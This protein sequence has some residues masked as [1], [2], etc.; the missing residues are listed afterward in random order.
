MS[1]LFISIYRYLNRRRVLLWGSLFLITTLLLFFAVRVR[2][3]EDP[4]RFFPDSEEGGRA[5]AL[6]SGISAKDRVVTL[7]ELNGEA[8]RVDTLSGDLLNGS[9]RLIEVANLFERELMKRAGESLIK[10]SRLTVD[11][12]ELDRSISY[13]YNNLPIFME[14]EDYARLDSAVTP[15][16]IE[17]MVKGALSLLLSPAGGAFAPYFSR[18]PLNIGTRFLSIYDSLRMGMRFRVVDDYIFSQDKSALLYII[19]PQSGSGESGRNRELASTLG[20][21]KV[22]FAKLA[23]DVKISSMGGPVVGV[24]NAATIKKDTFVT[25]TIA[26]FIIAALFAFTFRDIRSILPLLLPAAFGALFALAFMSIRD[27]VSAIAI[28]AGAAVMGIALSY[29]IHIVSHLRHVCSIEQLLKDL[30]YPLTVGSFTTIGAFAGLQFTQSS[31]LRDF[32]LFSALTLIGTTLF[33]LIYLPHMLKIREVHSVGRIILWLERFS[34]QEFE[35]RRWLIFAIVALFVAGV[36]MSPKVRFDSDM[37]KLSIEPEEHIYTS[38]R[39][40]SLFGGDESRVLLLS[41]GESFDMAARSYRVSDSLINSFINEGFVEK[42]ASLSALLPPLELQRERLQTWSEFW[43]GGKREEVAL[44]LK[45]SAEKYGLNSESFVGFYDI[46]T[47]DYQCSQIDEK[48]Y[49]HLPSAI[50]EWVEGDTSSVML[51][52]QL[53]IKEEMKERVYGELALYKEIVVVDRAHF[54]S[55]WADGIKSD[56]NLILLI[57]SLLVFVT[58]LISYGRVELAILAF[59]PMFV[60]WV[61]ILGL[62]ALFGIPFNIVNILLATF[63]FGIGDDFSIF[64]LDG[65]SSEYE[66]GAKTLSSHK[67]AIFFST[68]TVIIGMG[69]ML[70]AQ[71]PALQSV[72]L[73]SVLG[74]CAVWIVAY[75]IQP[76]LYR[77]LITTPA[78]RGQTPVTFSGVLLMLLTFSV[79]TFG[80][81]LLGV[82][83]V[84]LAFVPVKRSVKRLFFRKVLRAVVFIPVRLSPTVRIFREN[85][86]SEDFSK[87]SVIVVN[88]QSFIDILMMLSLYPKIV[89]MTNSWV[90]NS[91]F[92]GHIVRYAGFLYHNDG[93]DN[94]IEAIKERVAEGYS[95]LIFPEGTRSDD[96]T[97]HRFHKGAFKIAKELSLDIL[98]VV[99]Y[100]NGNLLSKRQPFYIK[101]GTIGYRVL[102][103]VTFAERGSLC[104]YR[105]LCK[106][107]NKSM[108]EEYS[109]LR[110]RYD[111]PENDF[112]YFATM[113]NFIFKGPVLEWYMRVKIKMERRYS[114]FH[115]LIPLNAR[116]TDLGCGYGP[117]CFML[118]LTSPGRVVTGIDYDRDK[119]EIAKSCYT[120]GISFTEGDI[121]MAPIPESDVFIVCDTLHYLLPDNQRAVL[122]RVVERTADGGFIIIRDGDSER[123]KK[124]RVTKLSEWFSINLLNFNKSV[125]SPCFMGKSEILSAAA[126]LGCSVEVRNNDSYTS[127]TIYILR[128][129][130][131]SLDEKI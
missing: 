23:P 59:L 49:R 50:Q 52:S 81:L 70:F 27:G 46:I 125:Q 38:G 126:E 61:I 47:R 56:F 51:V 92:F 127:N 2:L 86:F 68:L 65:L 75:T 91:P 57:S 95:V 121:N 77:F 60:S 24:Y 8:D 53:F 10:S 55:L 128:P 119:I 45:E 34:S 66:R 3:I 117:L 48:D 114:M 94:H 30:A 26:I 58:L 106:Q 43:G 130:N 22:E 31:L 115:K 90:W 71:H 124:H 118:K 85:P 18:D 73:V 122:K 84:I 6:F 32:G 109:K 13:I 89:M 62:M 20:N 131:K 39:F 29:S 7:F 17:G 41:T 21:L 116:V 110:E 4:T 12:D 5:A 15:R 36:V 69:A 93:V 1:G 113:A 104:E 102:E 35:K 107:V 37:L 99:I 123:L 112:F 88:H 42:S 105:D 40:D 97:I 129:Q 96:M 100:G 111:T 108:R 74:M 120:K 9:G 79:F 72:A 67:L 25:L 98:P 103:R 87:P 101:P 78:N 28:G 63:I 64:V 76:I 54:S 80:C 16:A 83:I 33:S 44:S 19:T 82:F 14:R 11:S